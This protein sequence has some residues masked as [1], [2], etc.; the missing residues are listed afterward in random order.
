ML[1]KLLLANTLLKIVDFATTIYLVNNFGYDVEANPI[2]R[3]MFHV[4][5]LPWACIIAFSL[6]MCVMLILYRFKRERLLKICFVMML[7]VAISNLTVIIM[8]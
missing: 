6:Y 4:Y 3:G 2:L 5:G 8:G 1:V 7:C